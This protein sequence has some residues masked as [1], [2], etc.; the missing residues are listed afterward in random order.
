M[1]KDDFFFDFDIFSEPEEDKP[2][3]KTPRRV[4]NHADLVGRYFPKWNTKRGCRF[5]SI[6]AWR[7]AVKRAEIAEFRGYKAT[8]DDGIINLVA[9]EIAEALKQTFGNFPASAFVTSAPRGHSRTVLHF[10]TEV[11]KRLADILGLQYVKV[12]G[13]RKCKGRSYYQN[14]TDRGEIV[15]EQLPEK[16][17][18]IFFDDV[19]TTAI[20]MNTFTDKLKAA[21][22]MVI[23]VCWIYE[24]VKKE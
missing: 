2:A 6:R 19:V 18:A 7:E 21:G 22:Y 20:T 3:E 10:A 5:L 17:I 15:I 9:E 14:H 4:T 24:N 8:C 12:F 16:E 13:D 11:S 1:T 23:P